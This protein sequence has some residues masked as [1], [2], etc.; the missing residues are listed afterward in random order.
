MSEVSSLHTPNGTPVGM[1]ALAELV[2]RAIRTT[3]GVVRLEPT[4]K[5]SL[6]RL[7]AKGTAKVGRSGRAAGIDGIVLSVRDGL[8]AAAVDITT[9]TNHA[10]VDVADAVQRTVHELLSTHGQQPGPISVNVLSVE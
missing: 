10:A 8:T 7:M 1:T 2:A 6:N 9:D 4:M 3:P 5:N